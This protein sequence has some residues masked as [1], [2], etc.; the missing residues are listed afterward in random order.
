MQLSVRNA[1]R[2]LSDRPVVLD[3]LGTPCIVV[4]AQVKQV[5]LF[6]AART[7]FRAESTTSAAAAAAA[8]RHVRGEV[9]RGHAEELLLIGHAGIRGPHVHLDCKTRS[10]IGKLV[11]LAL[12]YPVVY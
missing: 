4:G 12:L 11:A 7:T 10:R 5:D 3:G 8:F 2:L 1:P 6:A 9:V